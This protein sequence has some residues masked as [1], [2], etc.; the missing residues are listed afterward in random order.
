MLI[1]ALLIVKKS[2]L[3]ATSGLILTNKKFFLKNIIIPFL[4]DIQKVKTTIL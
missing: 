2:I 1:L 3:K 4:S